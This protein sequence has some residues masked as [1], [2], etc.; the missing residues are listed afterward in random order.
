LLFWVLM[1]ILVYYGERERLKTSQKMKR[2]KRKVSSVK[3]YYIAEE[4]G[5]GGR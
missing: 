1:D 3:H 4:A 2:K 5:W